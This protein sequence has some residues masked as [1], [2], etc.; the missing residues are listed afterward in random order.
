M[1][2]LNHRDIQGIK[3]QLLHVLKGTDLAQEYLEGK[4]H[5]YEREEYLNL[6]IRCIE[7]LGSGDRH[8]QD[9]RRRTEGTFTCSAMDRQEERSPESSASSD[10]GM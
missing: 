1:E 2:Y 7:H 3:L 6:L 9:D 8:T 5:V 10:E 4:F